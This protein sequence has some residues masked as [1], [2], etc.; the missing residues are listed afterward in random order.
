MVS[1]KIISGK[2][3]ADE[4]LA[5]LKQQIEELQH[6]N[7]RIPSLAVILVGEDP[8]SL[9]YVRNKKTACSKVGINSLEYNLSAD[10]SESELLELVH[11]LNQDE[12]VDG[13]LVQLPLPKHLDSKIIIDAINPAK[14]VDGFCR[15]NVGSLAVN[16]ANLCPCTPHGVMY[17]LDSLKVDYYGKHAVVLGTSNIVGRPMALELINRGATVTMCNS[18]SRPLEQ[19]VAS[20]DIL[21][22]AIG[23]PKFISGAWLK[24]GAIAIDVGINRLENGK[25]CGDIDF[26]SALE[27][28][29][30][31]TPVPGGVGPMTIAMLLQNTLQCYYQQ[32]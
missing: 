28:V 25:L 8:A 31:I 27:R 23:K 24:P 21:I 4:I 6:K 22:A 17:L 5:K 7:L 3:A 12:A 15:Y 9:V 20:A 18:K 1:E 10:T 26:E 19:Y 14:D 16:Q 13:I 2:Q 11:K 29:K 30:Y 32:Q